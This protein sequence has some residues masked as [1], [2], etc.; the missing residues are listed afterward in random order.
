MNI[1]NKIDMNIDN[2]IIKFNSIMMIVIVM[3]IKI[4]R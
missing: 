2:R 4:D 1:N 3:I